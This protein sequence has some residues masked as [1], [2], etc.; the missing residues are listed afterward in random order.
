MPRVPRVPRKKTVR[1]A[2][3]RA[4][5]RDLSRRLVFVPV[6]GRPQRARVYLVGSAR[7]GAPRGAD[8]DLLVVVPPGRALSRLMLRSRS[9]AAAFKPLGP[10]T[11]GEHH[12]VV[13]MRRGRR[14]VTLDLFAT[15][16]RDLPFA[17]FHWTGPAAYNVRTRAHA[18]R[19]GLLLN[20]YGLFDAAGR[21]VGRARTERDVARL[22]G[23][24]WR[25]PA[26]R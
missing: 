25:R 5:A 19:R 2:T 24:S 18:R 12:R 1:L 3:A 26:D 23:V 13:K 16:R 10:A 22:L 9:R 17:L 21:R 15:T 4:V 11:G 6:C 8:V 7:R 14:V 20:Q